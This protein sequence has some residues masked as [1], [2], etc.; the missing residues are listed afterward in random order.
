MQGMF[1]DGQQYGAVAAKTATGLGSFWHPY[2][3]AYWGYFGETAF[4]EQPPLGFAIQGIAFKLFGD[5]FLTERIFNTVL[6]SISIWLLLKVWKLIKGEHYLKT[7]WYVL[8]IYLSIGTTT[9]TYINNLWEAQLGLFCLGA[10]YVILKAHKSVRLSSLFGYSILGGILISAAVMVK[11]VPGLFP[12]VAPAGLMLIKAEKKNITI[13]LLVCL[14]LILCL[15]G[16]YFSSEEAKEAIYYYVNNR[17]LERINSVP[18]VSS[19]F[20]I[21]IDLLGQLIPIFV[22]TLIPF[23][24]KIKPNPTKKN[25]R[26][27]YFF[28]Y[29]GLSS[30]LPLMLTLVQRGF[31]LQPSY[32]YF[33]LVFALISAD[34]WLR[35][36]NKIKQRVYD[37]LRKSLMVIASISLVLT[38]V[39][40]GSPKRDFNELK[41]LETLQ[42]HVQNVTTIHYNIKSSHEHNGGFQMYLLRFT[43]IDMTSKPED[44]I[45]FTL[46]N[47]GY[48]P[49][50]GSSLIPSDLILFDLYKKD[51]TIISSTPRKVV[52]ELED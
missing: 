38:V 6:F 9:W 16:I 7:S 47:K 41:D 18:T 40:A 24:L 10:I 21:L 27:I 20:H 34:S 43:D 30:S 14:T 29:V 52:M 1:L 32:Y 37:L 22:L 19:H 12:L 3:S 49:L 46:Q 28:L 35:I 5:S 44:I 42:K 36:L 31:Y 4:M 2:I 11:G 45:Q 8:L 50:D 17:L 48:P 51:S 26:Y 13:Q 25:I 39:F 23:F 15:A 33:I